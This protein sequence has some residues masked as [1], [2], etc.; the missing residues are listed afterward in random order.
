MGVFSLMQDSPWGSI[1]VGVVCVTLYETESV[2]VNTTIWVMHSL[3]L[4]S[5]RSYYGF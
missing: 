4:M 1:M 2:T 3:S 5:S